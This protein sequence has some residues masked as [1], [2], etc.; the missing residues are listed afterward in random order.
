MS[1]C[2]VTGMEQAVDVMLA[3]VLTNLFGQGS[4]Q[5]AFSTNNQG[6]HAGNRQGDGAEPDAEPDAEP[7]EMALARILAF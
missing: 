1:A 7:G 6:Q 5:R 4:A 2:C 3:E